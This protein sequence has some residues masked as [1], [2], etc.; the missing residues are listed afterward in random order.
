MGLISRVSSRT[1]RF[2]PKMAQ[3]SLNDQTIIQS[4][5][6]KLKNENE[7]LKAQIAE[8]LA[9]ISAIEIMN[10]KVSVKLPNRKITTAVPTNVSKPVSG[11]G[12]APEKVIAE[13]SKSVTSPPQQ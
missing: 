1:Y 7:L 3:N 11:K 10:G 8:M 4:R 12:D 13:V 2:F 9:Q 5:K 6:N